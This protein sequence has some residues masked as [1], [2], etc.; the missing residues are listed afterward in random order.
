LD[1]G[2]LNR[3]PTIGSLVDS[4]HDTDAGNTLGFESG[5]RLIDEA[6]GGNRESDPLS[7]VER[8]L[9]DVRRC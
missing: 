6:D 3:L 4:L 5:D 8:A 7:L 1:A 2:D 9:D